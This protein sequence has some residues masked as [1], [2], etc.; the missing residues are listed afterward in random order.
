[1]FRGKNKRQLKGM[2][3]VQ[4]GERKLGLEQ[5]GGRGRWRWEEKGAIAGTGY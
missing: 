5:T 2:R 4:D 3:L 1:M